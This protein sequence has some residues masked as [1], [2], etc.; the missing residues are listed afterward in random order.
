MR[1]RPFHLLFPT[2]QCL[3]IVEEELIRFESLKSLD[4]NLSSFLVGV[5]PTSLPIVIQAPSP[6]TSVPSERVLALLEMWSQPREPMSCL[7]ML[8]CWCF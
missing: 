7:H 3:E 2:K 1:M 8:T 5:K 6:Y 4:I